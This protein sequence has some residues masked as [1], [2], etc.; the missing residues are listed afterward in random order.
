MKFFV[1]WTSRDPVFQNYDPDCKVL[2]SPTNVPRNWTISEWRNLPDELFVDSGSFSIKTNCFPSCKEVLDRQLLLSNNWPSSRT[3][4]FSHP[5]VMLPVKVTFF[6]LNKRI[7]HSIERAKIYFDSLQRVRP[8]ITPVGVLHGYDEETLLNTYLE[9]RQMGYRHFALG[10][11]ALRRSTHR[12]LCLRAI[13]ICQRYEIKPLHLFGI[14]WPINN[15]IETPEIAS[16]DSSAPVKLAIY[17]TVLYGPPLKRYVIRP[18]AQQVYRDR[19]FK[20]RDSLSEPLACNCPVC[21]SDPDRIIT[22]N[23]KEAK[24]HRTIH[25]YFQIKWETETRVL[26][27]PGRSSH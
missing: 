22:K 21:K 3:L 7:N 15:L 2:V 23:G 8:N 1:S 9:L 20:F 4:Y 10:S 18:D 26:H 16:F 25:N 19:C 11:L 6:E 12:S 14:T 13:N 27:G 5:D 24:F 17:G